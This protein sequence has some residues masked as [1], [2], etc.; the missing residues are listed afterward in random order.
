[1]VLCLAMAAPCMVLGQAFKLTVGYQPYDTISYSAAVI[2][3]RGLWKKYLPSGSQ[4]RFIPALQ[5][6]IIA[7][8]MLKGEAQIGYLGDMP[9]LVAVSK[10]DIAS[11]K[12]VASTGFSPGQRCDLIM[13]RADAPRF[14]SP[15]E[16]VTWLNG[17]TFV[18]PRGSCADRFLGTLTRAGI[19]KPG[20]VQYAPLDKIVE[21]LRARSV[22]AAVLWEPTAS[23]IGDLVGEGLARIV[24]TG[25][26]YENRDA[27]ALAMRED[28]M[29]NYPEVA[30]GWLR[31][32]LEA[33]RFLLDPGNA[34]EVA[35][36]VE[37]QAKGISARVAWFSLYGRIPDANGGSPV[38]DVKPFRLDVRIRL[39]FEE[40]YRYLYEAGLVKPA[41]L[42]PGAID[43]ALA[44]QL[45]KEQALPF[46]LGIINAAPLEKMPPGLDS[47][48][49]N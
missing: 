8:Q 22:D 4:V 33:Q 46:P 2:R 19:I 24:V 1:L 39:F 26:T 25:K 45:A 18:T 10:R 17:K 44:R 3:A 38:R 5:G 9:A 7:E 14:G 13:V 49:R 31:T 23:R 35:K 48:M 47:G 16:A 29:L 41:V 43:D 30:M 27:G 32:E 36:I 28:F 6:S 37:S 20:L 11:I 15:E 21:K 42:P 40:S 12:I 34:A